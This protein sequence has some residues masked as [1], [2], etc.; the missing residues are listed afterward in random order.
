MGYLSRQPD[1]NEILREQNPWGSQNPDF[2]D[3]AVLTNSEGKRCCVCN[4][5]VLNRHLLQNGGKNYCPDHA[6]AGATK[7]TVLPE[8]HFYSASGED[9]EAD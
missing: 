9:G 2:D 8:A 4:R 5:V 3:F 7:P 6:P 1:S